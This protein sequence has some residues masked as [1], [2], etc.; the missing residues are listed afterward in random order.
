MARRVAARPRAPHDRTAIDPAR[1]SVGGDLPV[2]KILE[3]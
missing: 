2:N 3:D 1:L